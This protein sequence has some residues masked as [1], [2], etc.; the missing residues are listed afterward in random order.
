MRRSGVQPAS[1]HHLVSIITAANNGSRRLHKTPSSLSG[2][3]LL[4]KLLSVQVRLGNHP[5]IR[6]LG[7][8][9]T[10]VNLRVNVRRETPS[11]LIPREHRPSELGCELTQE[12]LRLISVPGSEPSDTKICKL[13]KGRN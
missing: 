6:R 10:Q 9:D 11:W 8:T 12:Y 2:V 13:Y 1:A 3:E 7:R 5:R 4:R